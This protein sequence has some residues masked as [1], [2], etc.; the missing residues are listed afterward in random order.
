MEHLAGLAG[1]FAGHGIWCVADG[2]ALTPLI[3]WEGIGGK[4]QVVHLQDDPVDEA[5]RRGRDWLRDNPERAARAVL[6]SEV[7][8]PDPGGR[9]GGLRIEA[10]W[11]DPAPAAMTITVPFRRRGDGI[12][13]FEPLAPRF[14]LPELASATLRRVLEESFLAGLQQ[15]EQ[16]A[17]IWNARYRAPD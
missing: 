3:A 5:V 13:G 11:Y 16:G 10:R 1:F 9:L 4:R 8:D 12:D 14:E 6:L 17:P 15:H 2:R 7:R